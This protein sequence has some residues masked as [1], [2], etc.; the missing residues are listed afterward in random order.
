MRAEE[1]ICSPKLWKAGSGNTSALRQ[2]RGE[3]GEREDKEVENI[4]FGGAHLF[5]KAVEGS[6]G[7]HCGVEANFSRAILALLFSTRLDGRDW[8]KQ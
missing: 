5:P 2:E 4:E 1:G 7:E 3:E 8:W 6:F